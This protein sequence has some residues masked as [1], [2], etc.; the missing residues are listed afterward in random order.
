MG[1]CGLLRQRLTK[2]LA[3]AFMIEKHWEP[4]ACDKD[5]H[6]IT[7]HKCFWMVDLKTVSAYKFH[8][9]W[10]ERSAPLKCTQCAI[11]VICRHAYDYTAPVFP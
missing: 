8:G 2:D 11:E 10:L 4:T 9:E 1:S 5:S 6:S 7:K 3:D